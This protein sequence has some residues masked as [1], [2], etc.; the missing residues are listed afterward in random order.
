MR[1]GV[2]MAPYERFEAFQLCHQLALA[3]YRETAAFPK[4]EQY[5][6]TAQ[7]RRA[8]FSAPANI[9]EGSVKRGRAEFRRFLDIALGSL[10]ELGYAIR[11]AHALGYLDSRR[12]AVL[13]ETHTRASKA[14][15]IL[16]ASMK[17]K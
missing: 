4:H 15:W 6:L 2:V 14:T 7:A 1:Y 11:F 10:A 8:A 16:Y 9:V 17:G 13:D 12:R 3:L 5:G